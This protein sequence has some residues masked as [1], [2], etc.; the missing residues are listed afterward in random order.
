MLFACVF[1]MWR[2]RCAPTL[3]AAIF[4]PLRS[5]KNC[6]SVYVIEQVVLFCSLLCWCLQR[7]LGVVGEIH[8]CTIFKRCIQ[9][10]SPCH[11]SKQ[12]PDFSGCA[13]AAGVQLCPLLWLYPGLDLRWC[14]IKKKDNSC[15]PSHIT[16]YSACKLHCW[17]YIVK[18]CRK[19]NELPFKK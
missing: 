11:T 14:G 15:I 7:F 10:I 16:F 6:R 12:Q 1:R 9:I 4:L 2:C 13:V 3:H 17:W 19:K 8:K 5:F 18:N